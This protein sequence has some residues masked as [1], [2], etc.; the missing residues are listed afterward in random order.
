MQT[1]SEY[2]VEALRD[3]LLDHRFGPQSHVDLARQIIDGLLERGWTAP[4]ERPAE[5]VPWWDTPGRLLRG[6]SR[7]VFKAT[8]ARVP[9][10][11]RYNIALRDFSDRLIA[12]WP[13]DRLEPGALVRRDEA[14]GFEVCV[15]PE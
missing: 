12:T 15:E 1:A 4:P 8:R 10:V 11:G 14:N 6:D 7:R 5:W 9:A 2:E 13:E 3:L